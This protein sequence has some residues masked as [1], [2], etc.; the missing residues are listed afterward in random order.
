[1]TNRLIEVGTGSGFI[2]RGEEYD[3]GVG[4]DVA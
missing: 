4:V 2:R 3:T 1:M